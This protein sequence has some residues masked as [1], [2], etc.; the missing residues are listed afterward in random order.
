MAALRGRRVRA[1]TPTIAGMRP[2]CWIDSHLNRDTIGGLEDGRLADLWDLVAGWADLRTNRGL[3]SGPVPCVWT[4]KTAWGATAVQIV[5]A[6]VL[7]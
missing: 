4:V 1:P 3:Q 2:V 6:R 7:A 5:A